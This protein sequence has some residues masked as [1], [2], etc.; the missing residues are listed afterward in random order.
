MLFCEVVPLPCQSH[1]TLIHLLHGLRKLMI[2]ARVEC[3]SQ[4]YSLHT[5]HIQLFNT[6]MVSSWS[7][8]LQ[9]VQQNVIYNVIVIL[10]FLQRA[11]EDKN[12]GPLV[13]TIMTRCIHCTRCI[14]WGKFQMDQSVFSCHFS[15]TLFCISS[16]TGD[17]LSKIFSLQ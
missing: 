2:S 1:Y 7:L 6:S 3:F 10:F 13:K 11:V 9:T 12:V 5:V 14:R 8:E 17:R 15:W 4:E 16:Q